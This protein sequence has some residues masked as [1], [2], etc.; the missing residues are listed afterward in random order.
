MVPERKGQTPGSQGLDTEVSVFPG[1]E[2]ALTQR[3]QGR[4]GPRRAT[5]W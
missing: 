3:G 1:A 4:E 2:V 5:G